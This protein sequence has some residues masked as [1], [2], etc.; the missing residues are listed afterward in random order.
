VVG[1][2]FVTMSGG[3]GTFVVTLVNDLD[4]RVRVGLTATT[5]SSRLTIAPHEPVTLLAKQRTTVRMAAT[6]SGIGVR[7]A[8]LTPVTTK[9]DAIGTPISFSVRSS[10]VG[11]LIWAI[12]AAGV[13]LLVVMIARRWIKRGL[14]R[15][16]PAQ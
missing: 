14:S 16:S 9:G 6:S 10:Q 13:A 8:T 11:I 15:R 2:S 7:E 12:M 4:E 3:S 5:D 1:S